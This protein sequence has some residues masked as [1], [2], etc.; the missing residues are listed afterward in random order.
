MS[1]AI[2]AAM[3]LIPAGYFHLSSSPTAPE[4]SGLAIEAAG[5]QG[6]QA[7]LDQPPEATQPPTTAPA[8]VAPSTTPPPPPEPEVT[9]LTISAVGD[10][11]F[12]N[13]LGFGYGGS[14]NDVYERNGPAFFF[15]GVLPVLAND[16]LTIA[17]LEG[18]LTE[19]GD[20]VPKEFNFRGL[21]EYTD[22]LKQGSV[23]AVTLANNHSLDYGEIGYQDT[24]EALDAAG[25]V[26]FGYENTAVV[27]V[28]GITIG[29][30]GLTGWDDSQA[31]RDGV[32]QLLDSL[33]TDIKIVTYHWGIER[34][35]SQNGGQISLAHHTI[36]SG[37]DLV[38]GGHPH[39]LQGVEM[40]EGR[41][42][43]YSLGNFSFGGN[44][45]PSDKDSMIFQVHFELTD[46]EISG[47]DS[48]IIPVSISSEAGHNNYS[49]IILEGA[50]KDRVMNK[51]L[52]PSVNY[53]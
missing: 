32:A 1:V 20:P 29:L 42:I 38:L 44:S 13:G 3:I 15:Q 28:K 40:Y 36:D 17:N 48:E 34:E 9:T 27:E 46:G 19:R 45:N 12:G 53:P 10:C 25:I 11:T 2:A 22:V 18:P 49:P 33:D 5:A 30:V 21:A 8:E 35:Y 51:V 4:R 43:V 50:E 52:G 7:S 26:H 6:D 23:E 47:I 37:A 41:P 14:F 39:V 31:T 16:D 24:I